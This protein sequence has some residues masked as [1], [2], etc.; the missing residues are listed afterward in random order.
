MT[1]S[2]YTPAP[3]PLDP[4]ELSLYVQRELLKLSDFVTDASY[5]PLFYT[6][7]NNPIEGQFASA[8]G[9][10]WNPGSG[11]G[12]YIYTGGAWTFIV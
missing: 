8:D 5:V 11:A 1:S 4:E 7:P 2:V 3:P 9:T 6:E 10:G 12:F